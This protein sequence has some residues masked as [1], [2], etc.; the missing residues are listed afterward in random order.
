MTENGDLCRKHLH[1][2]N[3]RSTENITFGKGEKK[4]V[5]V[6]WLGKDNKKMEIGFYRGHWNTKTR[7]DHRIK[8]DMNFE[9]EGEVCESL[10]SNT[11]TFFIYYIN[12]PLE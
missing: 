4:V 8:N 9:L 5:G 12:I 7:E 6:T 2:V 10:C 11:H 3:L 1:E